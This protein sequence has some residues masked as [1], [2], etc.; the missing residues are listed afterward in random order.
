ME[1][2]RVAI[3]NAFRLLRWI[4]PQ[5]VRRSSLIDRLKEQVLRHDSIYSSLYY[6]IGVEGPAVRSAGPI[7]DSILSSF[8][9]KTVVDVGCGTG[10]LL[11]ALRDRGCEVFGVE[12]S[13]AALRFCRRRRL[14]VLK[15]DLEHDEFVS[16]R[17]FDVALSLEVAE[18]LPESVAD[19][20]VDLLTGLSRTV[21]FTAAPPGQGG[22]DH[23][24]E[25]PPSYWIGK[26]RQRGF[27]QDEATTARWREEWR[28][29]RR[30]EAW[31]WRN[32]IVFRQR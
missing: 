4:L 18:H 6:R 27:T 5:S 32:L 12:Y 26:F 15:L 3:R 30:V 23:A 17:A 10:A 28:Q 1:V 22:I 14:D 20:Y 29:T 7:A 25:Q 21:V 19:R 8:A 31:Y 11:S 16:N 24:N 13:E 2:L 9:P